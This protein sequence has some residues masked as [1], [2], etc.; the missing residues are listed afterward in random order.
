M[1]RQTLLTIVI[2]VDRDGIHEVFGDDAVLDEWIDDGVGPAGRRCD[3]FAD[4]GADVGVWFGELAAG[5][6]IPI[7]EE[8]LCAADFGAGDSGLDCHL[9]K[10]I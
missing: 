5:P 6:H 2:H 4:A 8:E 1:L 10:T 7:P 9:Q 3:I